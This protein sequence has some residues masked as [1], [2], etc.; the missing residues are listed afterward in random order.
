MCSGHKLT[1][2]VGDFSRCCCKVSADGRISILVI[3]LQVAYNKG[4]GP[5]GGSKVVFTAAAHTPYFVVMEPRSTPDDCGDSRV[6]VL[7]PPPSG[8]WLWLYLVLRILNVQ[9]SFFVLSFKACSCTHCCSVNCRC[10]TT[11][12]SKTDPLHTLAGLASCSDPL[13]VDPPASFALNPCDYDD[14]A[15]TNDDDAVM[16]IGSF[17][18]PSVATVE[19]R[20][21]NTRLFAYTS[22]PDSDGSSKVRMHLLSLAATYRLASFFPAL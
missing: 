1:C 22:C 12:Q 5:N 6:D 17:S 3:V 11:W 15:A 21:G 2:A 10:R 13:P 18:T 8:V 9:F 20:G 16:L 4:G 19:T 14:S 7:G